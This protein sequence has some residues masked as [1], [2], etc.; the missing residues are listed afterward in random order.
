MT[1]TLR[2]ARTAFLR[3]RTMTTATR[4]PTPERPSKKVKLDVDAGVPVAKTEDE[5]VE[6]EMSLPV[7]LPKS[8]ENEIDYRNK[9]VLAPMVRSGSRE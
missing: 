2:F 6:H 8:Y 9:L 4:S 1:L 5:L 3:L 7:E